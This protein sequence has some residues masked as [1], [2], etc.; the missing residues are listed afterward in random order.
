[1]KIDVDLGSEVEIRLKRMEDSINKTY[2]LL[3]SLSMHLGGSQFARPDLRKHK[4]NGK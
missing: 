1:M 3:R 4:S 2:A